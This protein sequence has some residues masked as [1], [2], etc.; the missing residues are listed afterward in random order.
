M[1]KGD[2][3]KTPEL[4]KKKQDKILEK[5]IENQMTE[6]SSRL[7]LISRED[8]EEQSKKILELFIQAISTGN[9]EDIEAPE[10]KPLIA[11][12]GELS[13]DFTLRGFTPSE[14]VSYIFSLKYVLIDILEQEFGDQP[15]IY[16]R[17]MKKL[18]K[19]LYK[20][21]MVTVDHYTHAQEEQIRKQITMLAEME[22]PIAQI[23]D[24]IL[25]IPI[26][27]SVDSKRTQTIMD[28]CLQKILDTESKVTILDITG[29]PAVDTAVANHIIKISKAT[30]L[31]GCTCIISGIVPAVAQSIVN[32]GIDIGDLVTKSTLKRALEYA[33]EI[34]NMELT[35]KKRGGK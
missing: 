16:I 24:K 35:E 21:G 20:L 7:D 19:L 9:L 29:V 30:R 8:L 6:F 34:L 17:E 22:T 31:M 5:W 10:Y 33:F 32:L 2:K 26:I 23:W 14:T 15:K 1:E 27:G 28:K 12:L 11:I 3:L 25:L 18:S 13:K 4:L